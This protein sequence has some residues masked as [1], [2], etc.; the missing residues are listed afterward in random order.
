MPATEWPGYNSH[1][2]TR[3]GLKSW[4]PRAAIAALVWAGPAIPC[5]AADAAPAAA[6]AA[7]EPLR[8]IAEILALSPA[9]I[10]A[11][12]EAV[13]RGVVTSAR[14]PALV[15]QEG[16]SPIFLAGFGRVEADDGSAPTIERGMIVEVEGKLVAAGYAPAII[17]RRTRIVGRGPVPPPVPADLG[18][19][20][21]GGDRGGGSR[22]RAW[23]RGSASARSG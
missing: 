15:I 17:G 10:D 4:L 9:E 5:L 3:G 23:C 12:P 8:S 13:V 7:R 18:R 6:P 14:P 21:R 20:A 16:D 11:Q 22:C 2:A 19:L 1:M